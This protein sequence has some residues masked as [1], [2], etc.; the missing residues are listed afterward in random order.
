MYLCFPTK[1]YYWDGIT[2]AQAIEDASGLN[3]SLL[4]PNH[5]LYEVLGYVFY[6]LVR[7]MGVEVRAVAALQIMNSLIGTFAAYLMFLILRRSLQSLYVSFALTLL[8]AFSATW[9][10]FATD[11]DA[12]IPSV[13]FILITFY[14]ILPSHKPRPFLIALTFFISMCFHQLAV[15]FYP[16]VVLGLWL[17]STS[18]DKRQRISNLVYFSVTAF[19]ITVATYYYCFFLVTQTFGLRDFT[20]WLTSFNRGDGFKFDAWSNLIFTLRGFPRLFFGGRF[21]L[22][23][24]LISPW[25]VVLLITLVAVA[26]ILAFNLIRDFKRLGFTWIRS[27]R[28]DEQW[29]SL[30]L[31]CVVWISIYL[32]FLFVWLPHNTFYRLF[33]LPALILLGGLVVT[34]YD[35]R[36]LFPRHYRLLLLVAVVSL[37]NFLFLIFPYSHAEKFPPLSF[38]LEMNQVWPR[39]TVVYYATKNSD[40]NLVRYFNPSTLWRSLDDSKPEVLEGELQEA[41]DHGSTVWLD[42]TAIDRFSSTARGAKWL[43]EHAKKESRRELNT[44]A[45]RILFVQVGPGANGAVGSED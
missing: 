16:V 40:N 24:G 5:L 29:R 27:I 13:L 31:L 45:Y 4:H 7:A 1:N 41:Y 34:R 32:I 14:L 17:Q 6:R 37:S 11:A 38:A 12:Y 35:T 28:N 25:I 36:D 3:S 18:L 19:I 42:A 30:A 15:M 23:E 26:L 2:F 39:G 33:F 9:W 44:R 10:R 43:S 8:F 21:N 22:I 20:R